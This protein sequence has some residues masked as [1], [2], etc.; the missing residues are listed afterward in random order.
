MSYESYNV[1]D[2][3]GSLVERVEAFVPVT[4]TCGCTPAESSGRPLRF[5][6]VQTFDTV[7]F[8]ITD[9]SGCEQ[10]FVFQRDGENL[11]EQFSR[12]LSCFETV[13]TGRAGESIARLDENLEFVV[14]VGEE[15]RYCVRASGPS[16]TGGD[17]FYESLLNCVNMTIEFG[18]RSRGMIQTPSGHPIKAIG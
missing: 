4:T 16:P 17:S 15:Y 7:A 6:P 3:S 8:E 13:Y 1:F 2:L 18:T 14:K 5:R 9:G 11:E 12:R 10:G